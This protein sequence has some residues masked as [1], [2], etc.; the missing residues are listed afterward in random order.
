MGL[1]GTRDYKQFGAGEYY[2]IYNRGNNKNDI[3]LD[4]QDFNYF[5]SKVRQNLFPEENTKFRS[6]PLP[7]GTFS[8]I[9]YC[10][11]PNH[12]H[13]LIR[14]NTNLPTSKLIL[15][16]CTSYSKYF[17][18][19]YEKVGHLFQDQFK[20]VLIDDNNY[21]R[22][23]SAYIHQN[24]KVAG[25]TEKPSEYRWSSYQEFVG[26][27]GSNLCEKEIILDQFNKS[28]KEYKYFV[29]SSYEIIKQNKDIKNIL[30]D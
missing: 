14:Q 1:M 27:R 20:Q 24:P 9:A 23:L 26:D 18:K 12:F 19:K 30:L 28:A 10:L 2:H 25:L 13:L 15:R 22:W 4:D 29:E 3:F 17:N 16:I 11:M 8:L 7:K 21:L 6:Q 5:V